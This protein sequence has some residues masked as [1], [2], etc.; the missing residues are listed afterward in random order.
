[1]FAFWS[2]YLRFVFPIK[3]FTSLGF[4]SVCITNVP[5]ILSFVFSIMKS[6]T[7]IRFVLPIIP[8][9]CVNR[10]LKRVSLYWVLLM[11]YLFN[12]L[13]NMC[14]I[15]S[16]FIVLSFVTVTLFCY[17]TMYFSFLAQFCLTVLAAIRSLL[18]FY[19]FCI[20]LGH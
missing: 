3:S 11:C 17:L 9:T 10:S 2:N 15:Q 13:S 5:I 8:S 6:F 16:R 4:V 19:I 1:M 18:N 14:S 20:I 7:V 12:Y